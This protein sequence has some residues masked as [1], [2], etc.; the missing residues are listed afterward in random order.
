MHPVIIV[1]AW[2]ASAAFLLLV[3]AVVWG[4]VLAARARREIVRTEREL[5]SRI[6]RGCRRTTEGE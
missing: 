5:Q 2:T 1:L 3:G 6:A 4:L